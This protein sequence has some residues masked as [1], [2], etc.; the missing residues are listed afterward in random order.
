MYECTSE[1][2]AKVLLNPDSLPSEIIFMVYLALKHKR[3]TDEH[4]TERDHAVMWKKKERHLE[5]HLSLSESPVN[6]QCD[7][8]GL[9]LAGVFF[10]LRVLRS[11]ICRTQATKKDHNKIMRRSADSRK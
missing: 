4:K 5:S 11:L 3:E 6:P 7:N 2:A 10:Q 1:A 8:F 9:L